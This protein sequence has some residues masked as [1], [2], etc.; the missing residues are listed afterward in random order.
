[1]VRFSPRDTQRSPLIGCDCFRSYFGSVLFSPRSS[2]FSSIFGIRIFFTFFDCKLKRQGPLSICQDTED[3]P[4]DMVEE[5]GDAA[6][7]VAAEV[8]GAAVAEGK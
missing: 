2:L 7:V 1:M 8:M 3:H 6:T 4:A 5:E